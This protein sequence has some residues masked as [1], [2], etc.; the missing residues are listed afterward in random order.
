MTAFCGLLW[1]AR[2]RWEPAWA[3]AGQAL[4]DTAGI[5]TKNSQKA[6]AVMAKEEMNHWFFS[7]QHFFQ[8]QKGRE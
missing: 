2:R 7:R 1:P 5:S 4:A 3:G 6:G 8:S